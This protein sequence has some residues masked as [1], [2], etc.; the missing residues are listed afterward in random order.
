[1]LQLIS[2]ARSQPIL[3]RIN[4]VSEPSFYFFFYFKKNQT[5][6]QFHYNFFFLAHALKKRNMTNNFDGPKDP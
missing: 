6:N 4:R 5:E 3:T 2:T 1:M